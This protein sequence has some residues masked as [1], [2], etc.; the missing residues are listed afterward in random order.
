[1]DLRIEERLGAAEARLR[2][3]ERLVGRLIPTARA[4]ATAKQEL[5]DARAE[6]DVARADA[7]STRETLDLTR[8]GF[9]EE[10]IAVARK[11]E[12]GTFDQ[13]LVSPFRP[14][15]I[16][17]AKS[18]PS[19]AF[20]L[21]DAL[22]LSAGAVLWFGVPFRGSIPALL[23]A[24]SAFVIAIVG[25]GLFISAISTTLQQADTKDPAPAPSRKSRL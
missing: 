4:R 17:V 23:A 13:L 18:L 25:I 24:L 20:G 15:E 19:L 3:A 10:E 2:N 22:L 1:V 11:R 5:D 12:F 14:F 16:L 9:R 8:E 7:D 21:L 6:L